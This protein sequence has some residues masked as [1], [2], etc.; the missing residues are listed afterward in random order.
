V[1]FDDRE[2]GARGGHDIALPGS[3]G[4]KIGFLMYPQAECGTSRLDCLAPDIF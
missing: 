1:N 4:P 2:R 3:N